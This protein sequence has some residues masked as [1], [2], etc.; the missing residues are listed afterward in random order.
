MNNKP[1]IRRGNIVLLLLPVYTYGPDKP[2]IENIINLSHIT[3]MHGDGKETYMYLDREK[4]NYKK[5]ALSYEQVKKIIRC[6][7]QDE[8]E[9]EPVESRFELLDI[10]E[11]TE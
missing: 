11:E 7:L 10:K 9:T 5:V 8:G 3:D 2:P 1:F 6:A 4:D